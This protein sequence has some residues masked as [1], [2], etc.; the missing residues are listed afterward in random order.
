MNVQ[1]TVVFLLFVFQQ[2]DADVSPCEVCTMAL[3][4]LK[5]LLQI[6][7]VKT[8]VE[9]LMKGVCAAFGPVKG[10]C[11]ALVVKGID[12][13]FDLIQKQQPQDICAKIRLC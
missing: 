7:A 13:V 8:E 1:F 4:Q 10:L 6:D 2:P 11:E 9:V 5:K 3:D 12:I